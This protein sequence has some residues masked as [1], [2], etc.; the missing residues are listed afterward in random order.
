MDYLLNELKRKKLERDS[1]NICYFSLNNQ[2]I[3]FHYKKYIETKY[4]TQW[5]NWIKKNIEFPKENYVILGGEKKLTPRLQTAFGDAGT[6]YTFSGVTIEPKLWKKPLLQLK[7]LVEDIAGCKFNFCLLNYYRDGNDSIGAHRDKEDEI[8]K[9]AP[10][11]SLTF[12]ERRLFK[13]ENDDKVSP[14]FHKFTRTGS[15]SVALED[16]PSGPSFH[17]FTRTGSNVKFKKEFFISNGDI[18][19]FHPPTNSFNKHSLPKDDSTRPRWNFTFRKL[20]SDK[21]K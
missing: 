16:S 20:I 10:I 17:K 7:K 6:R 3:V 5:I 11:A 15:P 18:V 8:D 9:T 4:C 19:I 1:K 13:F 2:F 21:I 12:G 14:S